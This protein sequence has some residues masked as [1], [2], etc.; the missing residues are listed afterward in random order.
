[1]SIILT[2]GNVPS[3]IDTEI[4]ARLT[5]GKWDTFLCIVPTNRKAQQLT[6]EFIEISPSDAVRGLN[7]RA[8][9]GAVFH[10]YTLDNLV[11]KLYYACGDVKTIISDAIQVILFND[12]INKLELSYFKSQRLGD[13]R[14][15]SQGT[16]VQLAKAINRLKMAGVYPEYLESDLIESD[17]GET[18]KLSD[19]LSIY[20]AYE[21]KLG[22]DF[23]DR[24][25][26]HRIVAERLSKDATRI[27][28]MIFPRVDVM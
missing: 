15:V 8:T 23:I 10:I 17:A 19:I 9:G 20:K 7:L 16:T 21:D 27:V 18:Q 5:S 2:K 1:M 25:G 13:Q 12:I 3:D 24:A 28:R 4:C 11:S 22:N 14:A 26:V 6:R